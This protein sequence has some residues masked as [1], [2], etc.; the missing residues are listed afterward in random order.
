MGGLVVTLATC[1]IEAYELE[2]HALI[3]TAA[4][5]SSELHLPTTLIRLGLRPLPLDDRRQTFLTSQGEAK[6]ISELIEFGARWEDD[7]TATQ[8]LRHFYDPVNDRPLDVGGAGATFIAKSP[9][10]ALEDAGSFLT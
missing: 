10:W 1:N 6:A 4:M 8:A 2:T 9:D 3:S 5:D 7:A